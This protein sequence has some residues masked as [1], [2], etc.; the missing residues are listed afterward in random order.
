MYI[1]IYIYVYIYKLDM[2]VGVLSGRNSNAVGLLSTPYFNQYLPDRIG[3][4]H[5]P[6]SKDVVGTK[7]FTGQVPFQEHET[8]PENISCINILQK[9]ARGV[10]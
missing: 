7:L 2:P 1:Y 10:L 4:T 9:P 8:F 6:S 5:R 3:P